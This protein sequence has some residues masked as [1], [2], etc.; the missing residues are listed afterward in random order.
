MSRVDCYGPSL[1]QPQ[2]GGKAAGVKKFKFSALSTCLTTKAMLRRSLAI[3]LLLSVA[4]ASSAITP[5]EQSAIRAVLKHFPDLEYHVLPQ[6]S[7]DRDPCAYPPFY[8]ITCSNG[9][10]PHILGL[11]GRLFF[12]GRQLCIGSPFSTFLF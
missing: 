8:G 9:T 11:Y 6:W 5:G 7:A 3:L 12:Y 4:C 1:V 10:D 2:N